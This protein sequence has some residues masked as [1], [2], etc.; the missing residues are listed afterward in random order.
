MK[1]VFFMPQKFFGR[2]RGNLFSRK[3]ALNGKLAFG[4]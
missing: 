1:E 4:F 2:V 3:V